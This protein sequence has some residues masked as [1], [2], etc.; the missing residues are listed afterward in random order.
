MYSL[1]VKDMF[2]D[3]FGD[4]PQTKILDFLADHPDYDYSISEIAKHSH[5]SRPTVYKIIDILIDKQLVMIT[6]EQGSSSLFKLN[7]HNS[8]VGVM[9]RFDAEIE[10]TSGAEND[11]KSKTKK[12]KN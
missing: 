6:R 5:V 11:Q 8:L 4:S 3:V 1:K 2:K 7:S 12:K 9:L 10:K